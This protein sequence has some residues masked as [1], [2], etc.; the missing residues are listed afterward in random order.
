[1]SEISQ[2]GSAAAGGR[3]ETAEQRG[4]HFLAGASSKVEQVCRLCI[5]RFV[6]G[7][8]PAGERLP[9]EALNCRRADILRSLHVFMQAAAD[10][11]ISCILLSEKPHLAG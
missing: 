6:A 2:A 8:Y 1:M 10:G 11:E 7:A 5:K 9:A 4:D 3:T